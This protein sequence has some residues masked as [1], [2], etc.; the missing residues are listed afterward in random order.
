[1]N[2]LK[3]LVSDKFESPGTFK[4]VDFFDLFDTEVS[5]FLIFSN[6]VSSFSEEVSFF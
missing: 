2:L 5:V 6:D 4:L 1:L 3:A